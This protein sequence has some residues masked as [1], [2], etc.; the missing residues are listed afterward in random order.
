MEWQITRCG[1]SLLFPWGQTG[2]RPLCPETRK[3]NPLGRGGELPPLYQVR[4]L[5]RL[6]SP[7]GG[8]AYAESQSFRCHGWSREAPEQGWQGGERL[9]RCQ[10]VS[11]RAHRVQSVHELT[12]S[13]SHTDT[14]RL[15]G[16]SLPL[17]RR[18]WL[19][20]VSSPEWIPLQDVFW[21]PSSASTP[22]GRIVEKEE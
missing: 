9:W 7:P 15:G 10:V 12:G 18:F 21:L 20:M 19:R 11:P 14:P 4:I 2:A 22:F 5:Q 1:S 13:S 3:D 6:Q 16:A 17:E 8:Q